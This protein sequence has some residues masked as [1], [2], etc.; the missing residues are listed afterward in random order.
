MA[1]RRLKTSLSRLDVTRKWILISSAILAL[2]AILPWYEDLDAFGAGDLYLGIT[3]PLFLVG[4]MVLASAVFIGSW[5]LLPLRGKRLPDIPV[6]EGALY[7]FLGIQNLLLLLVA[8]SVF[9]HPKFGVNITLKD[10]RFGMI[11]AFVG[12][13]AIIWSG[14][15]LYRKERRPAREGRMEPLVKMPE[16]QSDHRPIETPTHEPKSEREEQPTL[17]RKEPIERSMDDKTD[18]QPLRMDL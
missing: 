7:T 2:S 6:K 1:S 4:L 13:I 15:Q 5:I 9:F 18:P 12:V 17:P 14:Y 10:T 3:G 8:N 16:T 11:L